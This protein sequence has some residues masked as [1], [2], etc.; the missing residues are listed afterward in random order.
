LVVV[1]DIYR[2]N[3][4][5]YNTL[6]PIITKQQALIPDPDYLQL[7]DAYTGPNGFKGV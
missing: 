6:L 1:H 4:G 3:T 5:F 2:D 7:G